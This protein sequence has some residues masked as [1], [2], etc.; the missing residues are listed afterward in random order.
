MILAQHRPAELPPFASEIR[1]G[2]AGW[3]IPQQQGDLLHGASH[4]QRYANQFAVCEIN[5]SFH[6]AHMAKTYQRWADSVPDNFRFS[7]KLPKEVTHVRRLVD[8]AVVL[9]RFLSEAGALGP[10][11]GPLLIQLPP[12]LQFDSSVVPE[13][14]EHLR[15]RFGGDLVCEPRHASWFSDGASDTLAQ[16]RVARAVADPSVDPRAVYPAGWSDVAYFRLHGKPKVYYS[17]YSV[18]CLTAVALRLTK[19]A[20]L[21]HSTWCIFDNTALGAAVGN[22]QSIQELLRDVGANS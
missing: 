17:A 3:R 5:S 13:F 16:F 4:L 15:K 6:R 2:T 19:A 21:A 14:L 18:E 7:V 1:V 22:A 11:L 12:S 8:T 9:E 20:R 10:K